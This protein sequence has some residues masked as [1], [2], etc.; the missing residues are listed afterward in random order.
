MRVALVCM[1][2]RDD[3]QEQAARLASGLAQAV[4]THLFMPSETRRAPGVAHHFLALPRGPSWRKLLALGNP[5][6]HAEQA[7]RIRRVVP[8]VVHLLH[9]HPTHALLIPLLG[10]PSCLSLHD[11]LDPAAS[12][13]A[14]LREFMTHR[15][16]VMVDQLILHDPAQ[17]A[18]LQRL[19]LPGE[20]LS[21]A[22]PGGEVPDYLEA[23]RQMLARL[24]TPSGFP[25]TPA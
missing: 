6:R 4:E 9:P 16:L 25:A 15:A 13:E 23:Y 11:V 17:A 14:S 18:P 3:A 5:W 21:L 7:K 1:S 2:P 12:Q 10:M 22:S 19:G 24:R 20:R 8:D